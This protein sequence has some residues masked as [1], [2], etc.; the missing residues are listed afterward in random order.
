MTAFPK[1][2]REW[3]KRAILVLRRDLTR[4]AD[5]H[6]IKVEI[7]EAPGVDLYLKDESIHPS[8]SL[9]HRLARSLFLHALCDGRIGE[10]T[11]IVEASSGSTAISEA[12]FARLLGLRFI[13]VV[14]ESTAPAK[15]TAIASMG[16]RVETVSDGVDVVAAARSLASTERGCFLDQFANAER[17]TDW[18]GNNNIAETLFAQMRDETFPVPAWVVVGA[19][20]GGTSATIGRYIRYRPD[21][22]S[23]RLCVVD[24]E[25]SAFFESYKHNDAGVCGRCST[26][27]EGIGRPRVEASFVPSLVDRMY[28]VP[29]AASVAAMQWL[30]RRTGRRFGPSTGTNIIGALAL[31]RE[32]VGK[33]QPGSI[34]T[35]AC[36]PGE[37]YSD[38]VYDPCWLSQRGLRADP[39][40][41]RIAAFDAAFDTALVSAERC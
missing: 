34:V 9:K 33:G 14:P 4:S 39:W 16:G 31:A 21:L 28:S 25:G 27:V 5:T 10:S 26:I 12:F 2:D 38:T 37:R 6:L 41:E 29:D 22:A 3:V 40:L 18:R 17:V 19:G 13:A 23:V 35:L 1:P 32:L 30:E 15:L 24:P 11:L 20:T 7:P 36:D 8:G